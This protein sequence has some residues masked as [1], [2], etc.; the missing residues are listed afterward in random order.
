M[1]RQDPLLD[2]LCAE[3]EVR[4]HRHARMHVL[5][6]A[7]QEVRMED[8]SDAQCDAIQTHSVMPFRPTV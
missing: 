8:H 1:L 5:W 2:R 7:W 3:D 6:G 4:A